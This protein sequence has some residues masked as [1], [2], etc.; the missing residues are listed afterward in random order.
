M[1]FGDTTPRHEGASRFSCQNPQVAFTGVSCEAN[2]QFL[3]RKSDDDDA[4]VSMLRKQLGREAMRKHQTAIKRQGFNALI[5]ALERRFLPSTKRIQKKRSRLRKDQNLKLEKK[6]K[7]I[8]FPG[9]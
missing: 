5:N 6:T 1:P 7:P 4:L 3:L 2:V 9:V 8:F